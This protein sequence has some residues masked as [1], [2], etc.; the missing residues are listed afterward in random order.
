MSLSLPKIISQ[1][2]NLFS[3]L[4]IPKAYL[5]GSYAKGT[6]TESS[7][8]DFVMDFGDAKLTFSDLVK[9]GEAKERLESIFN[10]EVDLVISPSNRFYEKIRNHMIKLL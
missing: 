8:I 6:Q 3:E 9:I 2:K 5:F 7:D 4:R 1:S 10:K